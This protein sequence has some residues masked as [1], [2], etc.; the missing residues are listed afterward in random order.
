MITTLDS[1][2]LQIKDEISE[3]DVEI[4]TLDEKVIADIELEPIGDEE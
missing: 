4:E 2:M 1:R 3:F